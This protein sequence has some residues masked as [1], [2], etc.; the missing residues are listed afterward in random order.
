MKNKSLKIAL[1][2]I[3]ALLVVAVAYYVTLPPISIYSGEFWGFMLFI[4]VVILVAY[5]IINLIRGKILR[6]T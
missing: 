5:L 4:D 1:T 2:V 3:A 6:D